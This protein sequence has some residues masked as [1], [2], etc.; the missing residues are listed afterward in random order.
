MIVRLTLRRM[1][2]AFSSASVSAPSSFIATRKA[3]LMF[4]KAVSLSLS[5]R[6]T[7]H[8]QKEAISA[9]RYQDQQHIQVLTLS[10]MA[11]FRAPL[12]SSLM[13]M[14]FVRL[15]RDEALIVPAWGTKAPTRPQRAKRIAAPNRRM[16]ATLSDVRCGKM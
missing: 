7:H 2:I 13:D 14:S 10:F 5:Y 1:V 9:C 15:V 11:C 12:T 8:T 16:A 4:L 3:A 6:I